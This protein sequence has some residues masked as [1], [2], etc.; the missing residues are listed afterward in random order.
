MTN[1][2]E[3]MPGALREARVGDGVLDVPL[4]YPGA[5][6]EVETIEVG[7][8]HVRAADSIRI[9][10]DFSRDGYSIK[11]RAT[12]KDEYDEREEWREVAFVEAWALDGVLGDDGRRL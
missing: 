12:S 9:S 11:Q 4:W 8:V 5:P 7:L 6:G 10:Y 3:T 1:D 2:P